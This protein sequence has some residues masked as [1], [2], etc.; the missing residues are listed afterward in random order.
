M[1]TGW[2]KGLGSSLCMV[3]L[4]GVCANAQTGGGH[5][6]GS[7]PP[8]GLLGGPDGGPVPGP[9]SGPGT[10]NGLGGG[11]PSKTTDPASRGKA[12]GSVQFGPVG[13]W[14]DD[15]ATIKTIGISAA[16]KK[17]MDA[18]FDAN[19]PAILA[20][21]KAFLNEQS[22]LDFISKNPQADKS[23][24]FAAI[25]AVSQARAALQKAVAQMYLQIRQQMDPSQIEKLE[26]LE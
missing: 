8:P 7:P 14:W 21:Y 13:R 24:T 19:K 12:I 17:K 15:K 25:D 1:N 18:I 4:L 5:P 20:S 22:K 23:Q 10:P 26:K 2:L 6:G 11:P 3:L 16:Q 9:G